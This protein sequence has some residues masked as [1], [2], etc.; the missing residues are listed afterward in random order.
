ML[1]IFFAVWESFQG[2]C[3]TYHDYITAKSREEAIE[4]GKCGL[5]SKVTGNGMLTDVECFEMF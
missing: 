2:G 3:Y 5:Y 4:K 1:F